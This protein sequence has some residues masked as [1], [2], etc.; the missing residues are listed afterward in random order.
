[1]E[2]SIVKGCQAG[3]CDPSSYYGRWVKEEVDQFFA[4]LFESGFLD[5]DS[6]GDYEF[7]DMGGFFERVMDSLYLDSPAR[8]RKAPLFLQRQ[9]LNDLSEGENR[10]F[11][12]IEK[13]GMILFKSRVKGEY[14][15]KIFAQ[16]PKHL[17]VGDEG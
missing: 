15:K 6:A 2:E 12:R 10:Y 17:E 16:Y 3:D 4:D 13:K 14:H 1:M 8:W 11:D 7:R 9:I 5:K